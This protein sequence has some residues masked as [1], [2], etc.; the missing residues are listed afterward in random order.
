MSTYD[1]TIPEPVAPYLVTDEDERKA[2]EVWGSR[3]QAFTLART[4]PNAAVWERQ[5]SSYVEIMERREVET[6]Y[7]A[8]VQHLCTHEERHNGADRETLCGMPFPTV[9][10]SHPIY[11]ERDGFD[12]HRFAARICGTCSDV[13]THRLATNRAT[14]V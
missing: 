1:P 3:H 6:I 14:T 9:S 12:Q 2:H 11:D 10:T 7:P 8:P 4:Y 5:D 13:A